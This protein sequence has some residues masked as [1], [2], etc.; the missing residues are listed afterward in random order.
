MAGISFHSV[1]FWPLYRPLSHPFPR[2]F[3]QRRYN[4]LFLLMRSIPVALKVS[5][6][7][8]LVTFASHTIF[9]APLPV[10]YLGHGAALPAICF[11]TATFL[12][13]FGSK[14][15]TKLAQEQLISLLRSR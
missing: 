11:P 12:K 3:S 1:L 9:C 5:G 14:S 15:C 2:S 10:P 4:R 13:L 8:K 6:S 7:A